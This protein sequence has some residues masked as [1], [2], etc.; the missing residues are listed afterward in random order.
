VVAEALVVELHAVLQGQQM[1]LHLPQGE[2]AELVLAPAVLLR[3]VARQRVVVQQ[4]VALHV[5]ARRPL[6]GVAVAVECN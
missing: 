5:V 2:R 1:R 6:E 3:V 4:R